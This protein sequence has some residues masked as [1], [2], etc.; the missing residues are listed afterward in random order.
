M[1]LRDRVAIVSGGSSGIGRGICLEFARSGCKVVVAD[2]A[3][4]PKRGKYHDRDVVTTTATEIAK[5]GGTGT[6]V[7]ADMGDPDAI[8]LLVD[9]AV[10]TYGSLD[11]VVN[12][13]GIY[14]PGNSRELSVPDWDRVTAVNLRGLFVATKFAL[15]HL[16]KSASGRIINIASVHA[17]AGGGGPA[18]APAKAAS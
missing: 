4:K 3:E 13:A 8:E 5:E 6:F 12:N 9:Q 14:I 16:E 7:Q 17:F 11:I 15:P 10:A 1:R 2:I 18:Y